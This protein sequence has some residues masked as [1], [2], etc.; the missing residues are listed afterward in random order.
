M[1]NKAQK[2]VLEAQ[3]IEEIYS[4]TLYS[5]DYMANEITD[6]E[7]KI[8]EALEEDPEANVSW[9]QQQI[10]ERKVQVQ[11]LDKITDKILNLL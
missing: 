2:K 7:T 5:R 4:R 1:M 10:E 11:F 6:Y 3:A 8:R 9:Y